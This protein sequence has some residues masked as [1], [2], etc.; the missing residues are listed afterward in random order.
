MFLGLMKLMPSGGEAAGLNG[1]K[2]IFAVIVCFLLGSLHTI[3]IGFYAP[4]MALVYSLG[5]SPKVAFPIMMGAAAM[6]MPAASMK[7]VKTQSLDIKAS[8]ALTLAGIPGVLL[9]AYVVTS[10]PLV[11][12]KWVVVA[13]MV[14]TALVMFRSAYQK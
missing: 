9:A 12:L 2:L 11:A 5:M 3:G 4:C 10:L 6:L 8:I 14:Y 13:V 1:L 7:F